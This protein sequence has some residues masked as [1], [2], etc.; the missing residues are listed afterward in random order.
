M[1]FFVSHFTLANLSSQDHVNAECIRVSARDLHEFSFQRY[2][3][4]MRSK[5]NI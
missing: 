4:I 5:S 2:L 1:L 3:W